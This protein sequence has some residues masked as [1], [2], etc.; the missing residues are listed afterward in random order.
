MMTLIPTT[1]HN[2]N[3]LRILVR[4][5]Y[6]PK[7]PLQYSRSTIA[8]NTGIARTTIYDMLCSL[9][10]LGIVTSSQHKLN[11]RWHGR[12]TTLWQRLEG[13]T[14]E[15]ALERLGLTDLTYFKRKDD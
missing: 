3:N 5:L 13:V 4:Y 14:H 15:E 12:K 9:D 6:R 2:H 1:K 7:V 11:N 10:R 8:H